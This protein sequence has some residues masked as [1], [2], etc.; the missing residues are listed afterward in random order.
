MA[1]GAL[2]NAAGAGVFQRLLFPAA[3]VEV[4]HPGLD[5]LGTAGLQKKLRLQDH[6]RKTVY[7]QT[8]VNLEPE[9]RTVP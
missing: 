2:E 7:D 3:A 1:L 5:G 4:R 9:V 6:I 8:G